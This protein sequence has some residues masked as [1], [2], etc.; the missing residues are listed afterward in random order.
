MNECSLG[1]VFFSLDVLRKFKVSLKG[2]RCFDVGI[3]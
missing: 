2:A 3:D 1:L